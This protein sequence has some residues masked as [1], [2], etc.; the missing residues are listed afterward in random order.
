MSLIS[1]K[2][3]ANYKKDKNKNWLFIA[4]NQYGRTIVKAVLNDEDAEG[5]SWNDYVRLSGKPKRRY[6]TLDDGTIVRDVLITNPVLRNVIH[7]ITDTK[8]K[9]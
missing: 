3:V 7:L 5:I 8:M 6:R 1:G 9:G 2:V 4:S